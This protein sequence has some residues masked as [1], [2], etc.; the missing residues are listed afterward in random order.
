LF[1][2]SC[3]EAI[4]GGD[5][6]AAG[7]GSSTLRHCAGSA[8][9]PD[10]RRNE[11]ERFDG[12]GRRSIGGCR[13]IGGQAM[14]R[15]PAVILAGGRATR[16]GGSDKAFVPLGGRPLIDHVLARLRPQASALAISA[17]GDPARFAALG[18]PVLADT[19][20]GFP[21]PLAGLLAGIEWLRE[22]R[23]SALALLTVPVDCPVLPG[24]LAARL[25]A[26]AAGRIAIAA[27]GGRRHPVA[28]LWP[29]GIADALRAGLTD[30]GIR[31]VEAFALSRPHVTVDWPTEPFDPFLNINTPADLAAAGRF[32]G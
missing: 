25:H 3:L 10:C 14:T 27:S 16:L 8:T 17:N 19:V 20:P 30:G 21:G 9:R 1:N 2:A 6:Q 28:A 26:A 11:A 12:G 7:A 15:V 32:A 24:D 4:P 22:T 18:L 31:M 23:P 13:S 29:V 5:N